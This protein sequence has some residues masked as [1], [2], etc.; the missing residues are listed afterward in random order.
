MQRLHEK[1]QEL[2]GILLIE[3]GEV[4]L[5]T[6]HGLLEGGGWHI[7]ELSRVQHPHQY[8]E[9]LTELACTEKNGIS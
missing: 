2:L 7:T 9:L 6:A 1:G 4:G 5:K 3:P 8:W